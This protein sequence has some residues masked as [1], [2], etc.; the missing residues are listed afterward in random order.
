MN[1]KTIEI[2]QWRPSVLGVL[3]IAI[4]LLLSLHV[5]ATYVAN[6]AAEAAAASV[7]LA[8]VT[9]PLHA[10]DRLRGLRVF[11]E[12]ENPSAEPVEVTL[13]DVEAYADEQYHVHLNWPGEPEF[14]V[15]AHDTKR[16]QATQQVW[17]S[18]F[19]AWQQQGVVD[20][21]VEGSITASADVL[22]VTAEHQQAF[23]L[24]TD[25]HFF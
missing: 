7:E 2:R 20:V 5:G 19:S 23:E 8:S 6:R 13:A 3:L 21:S 12:V 24:S 14:E 10:S 22:W 17:Q 4:L 15:P 9:F 25:V 16:V 11:L 18:L 1:T